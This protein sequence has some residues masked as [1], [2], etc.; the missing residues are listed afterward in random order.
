MIIETDNLSKHFMRHEAVKG[1]SLRVPP[2][3]AFALIGA[4]GAGKT[5]LLRTLVNI[6]VPDSG[7]ATLIGVDSRR[8][9][10][11]DFQ[12]IGY[13]SE[14]TKLPD[15]LTI[16]QYFDYLR[17]LYSCWDR[18]LE[19][20]LRKRLEL[21]PSR[22]LGN[23][24]HGMRM[25][26]M[27]IGAL[28]FRPALLILDEPLSGLDPLVRDEIMEGLLRQAGETTIVIS[29]HE[30]S[31]I[32]NCVT[33][34]AFMDKGKLLFQQS[35]EELT[36]RFREVDVTLAN[37]TFMA[38]SMPTWLACESTNRTLRFVETSFIT[39]ADLSRKLADHFGSIG[40]VESRAMTL[41]EISKALMRATRTE[42]AK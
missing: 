22:K 33:H 20:E 23:L 38:A 35:I 7:S 15:R 27:L 11:V 40:S 12:R 13:V 21:P 1:V 19:D 25:K 29:S 42:A 26:A 32:E 34:V 30:L 31:E 3:A 18:G 9:S 10:H 28:A 6:L 39:D 24:S 37:T 16:A 14:N 2:G 41:R 4:N 17:A 36:A 8:L 5:T